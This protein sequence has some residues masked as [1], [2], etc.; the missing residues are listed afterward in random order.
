MVVMEEFILLSILSHYSFSHAL[1]S[2]EIRDRLWHH[3][4][5]K[6]KT[7]RSGVQPLSCP[8][9]GY[10]K[11]P[12]PSRQDL[13]EMCTRPGRDLWQLPRAL[14]TQRGQRICGIS[15]IGRSHI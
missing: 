14:Q 2:T 13:P 3:G 8:A 15:R 11:L 9:K 10:R 1:L 4:W 7:E 5:E 12:T 6:I